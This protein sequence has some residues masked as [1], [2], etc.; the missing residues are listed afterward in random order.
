LKQTVSTLRQ[1]QREDGTW[2][3]LWFDPTIPAPTKY[4]TGTVMATGHSLEWLALAPQEFIDDPKMISRAC[5]AA[6]RLLET[7][8]PEA[9]RENYNYYT[10]V[11]NSL[12]LWSPRAWSAAT[13]GM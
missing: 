8:P 9:L 5:E 11:A 12:K 7:I 4:L 10:H 13:S 1:T 6:L 3:A 2:D